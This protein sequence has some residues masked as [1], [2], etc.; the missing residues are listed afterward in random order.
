MKT[1][2]FENQ[3]LSCEHICL[4]S[5]LVSMQD[6]RRFAGT[7]LSMIVGDSSGSR[8]FW[9]LVDKALADT[10]SMQ[11]EAMDGT[12][13]LYS[14][15][16]S[17]SENV[18]KVLEIIKNVFEDLHKN[19]I[20]EDELRKAKNKVLSAIVI[21]SE[22]PMGLLLGLGINWVYLNKYRTI[23]DDIE[24]IKAIG[25]EDINSLIKDYDLRNFT[26]FSLGPVK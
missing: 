14:Y 26:R 2:S 23:Q 3:N 25:V 4:I 22:V 6:E 1:D 24:A 8:F 12:G 5:P 15:I 18:P 10:A 16:R 13:A 9:E 19:G 20:T 7:L 21:K 11:F 17:N